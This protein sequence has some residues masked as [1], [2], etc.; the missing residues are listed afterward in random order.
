MI[1]YDTEIY[2]QPKFKVNTACLEVALQKFVSWGDTVALDSLT[3]PSSMQQLQALLMKPKDL[4]GFIQLTNS[5]KY[6]CIP[7][8][9]SFMVSM[10]FDSTIK[11]K[12]ILNL[13]IMYTSSFPQK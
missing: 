2:F 9:E 7:D 11:I 13:F 12:K 8:P 4:T 5:I 3:N 10:I 6:H 1:F